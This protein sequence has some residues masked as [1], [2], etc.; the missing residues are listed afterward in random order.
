MVLLPLSP[1]Q[2]AASHAIRDR[3]VMPTS[4][5]AAAPAAHA[6]RDRPVMPSS[7]PVVS[8]VPQ[9]RQD[10]PVMPTIPT[11]PPTLKRK[12]SFMVSSTST[13]SMPNSSIPSPTRRSIFSNS[14]S[15]SWS[16]FKMKG[17]GGAI[18]LLEADIDRTEQT[19]KHEEKL[20]KAMGLIRKLWSRARPGGWNPRARRNLVSWD[21]VLRPSILQRLREMEH[22]R[23][24]ESYKASRCK[25][26]MLVTMQIFDDVLKERKRIHDLTMAALKKRADEEE[27][28]RLARMRAQ[29]ERDARERAEWERQEAERLRRE[30][31]ERARREWMEEEAIRMLDQQF[32]AEELAIAMGRRRK[33]AADLVPGLK[34][35][36][37]WY[38]AKALTQY[39]PNSI[40]WRAFQSAPIDFGRHGTIPIGAESR[41]ARREPDENRKAR[42]EA[43]VAA[44]FVD[45]GVV[46]PKTPVLRPPTFLRY[47]PRSPVPIRFVP[48]PPRTSLAS[49]CSSR[50][51]TALSPKRTIASRDSARTPNSLPAGRRGS[52]STAHLMPGH[53][54]RLGSTPVK[55]MVPFST[56]GVL[57][58]VESHPELIRSG[59]KGQ[60]VCTS[61]AYL[62]ITMAGGSPQLL[63]IVDSDD[64]VVVLE[65]AGL[66][67]KSWGE[68]SVLRLF[69][70]L[71]TL[72]AALSSYNEAAAREALNRHPAP[73]SHVEDDGG[74]RD[75]ADEGEKMTSIDNLMNFSPHLLLKRRMLRVH[76]LSDDGQLELVRLVTGTGPWKRD[77]YERLSARL[78]DRDWPSR[79][80][81][82]L[83][84]EALGVEEDQIKLLEAQPKVHERRIQQP[85]AYPGLRC[86][87]TLFVSRLH[88]IGLS[89]F[90]MGDW[91]WRPFRY[92]APPLPATSL[93]RPS[94][95]SALVSMKVPAGVAA[96]LLPRPPSTSS[97]LLPSLLSIQPSAATD[98]DQ[99]RPV[100]ATTISTPSRGSTPRL[101]TPLQQHVRQLR[102][103]R[104]L[105]ALRD[106]EG[107]VIGVDL[108]A[109]SGSDQRASQSVP[110][111][112]VP[113]P[114]VHSPTLPSPTPWGDEGGAQVAEFEPPPLSEVDSVLWEGAGAQGWR[115]TPLKNM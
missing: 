110:S 17:G 24:E 63:P 109:V 21:Y 75:A 11:I 85:A 33:A 38:S 72:K 13:S 98:D 60:E 100:T 36:P 81:V 80:A 107:H 83:V 19:I 45:S 20:K 68:E 29:A 91:V 46:R 97:S 113:N 8:P 111:Q 50:S 47:S 55:G 76:V 5:P 88:V 12:S 106:P 93:S 115:V 99:P 2:P 30:A 26:A 27:A 67:L 66:K 3:P 65:M 51:L 1:R 25:F 42:A 15:T 96:P 4:L 87:R 48:P 53:G 82:A 10:G 57:A 92:Q 64:L 37:T 102:A 104:A 79:V 84:M 70:E 43:A 7:L 6:V 49:L 52:S 94:S 61:I 112:S 18:A 35:H 108:S 73:T 41:T 89:P 114:P 34:Q 22:E 40:P 105:R 69:A 14:L 78:T 71:E 86:E 62:A 28:R 54:A 39:S 103:D 32:T 101:Q 77:S 9:A 31:E 16:R 58:P 44:S 56:P 95:R 74:V 23:I 59:P 90:G